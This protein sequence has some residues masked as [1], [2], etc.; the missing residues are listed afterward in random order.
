M[1]NADVRIFFTG[2]TNEPLSKTL[3]FRMMKMLMKQK[4]R[5][6]EVNQRMKWMPNKVLDRLEL[7]LPQLL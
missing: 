7:L 3:S 6:K 2:I 4:K 1:D 5:V